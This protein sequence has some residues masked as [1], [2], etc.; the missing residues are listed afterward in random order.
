MFSYIAEL[1]N[2]SKGRANYSR[3][4]PPGVDSTGVGRDSVGYRGS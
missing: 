3:S 1:R 2:I 4:E